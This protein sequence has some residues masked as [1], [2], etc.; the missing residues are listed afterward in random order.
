LGAVVVFLVCLAAPGQIF[1]HSSGVH[2]VDALTAAPSGHT[3]L[4]SS[5][6]IGQ[7]ADVFFEDESPLEDEAP[8][9]PNGAKASTAVRRAV[10]MA[11]V[12]VFS[13]FFLFFSRRGKRP[14]AEPQFLNVSTRR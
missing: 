4:H 10:V 3:F 1:S 6:G 14:R 12:M 9:P 5:G 13:F 2:V 8:M 11:D 7:E